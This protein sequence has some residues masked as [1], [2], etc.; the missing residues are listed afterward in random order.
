MKKIIWLVLIALM[1]L[2]AWRIYVQIKDKQTDD[3]GSG[4]GPMV[5]PVELAEVQTTTLRDIGSY[6]GS[7]KPRSGYTLAPKVAG[8]LNKLLVNLGDKVISGQ[9]IAVLDDE[10]YQQQLEQAK[11][12]QAVA[13]ATV[14]Q[15][16]LAYKAAEANWTATTSL[17]EQNYSSQAAMDQADTEKAAAKAKYDIALAE[18]QRTQSIVR[19]AEIQLAYTQI[20]ATWNGG[21]NYRLV[22]ERFA[23][24]GSLLSVNS[25]ILTLIDNSMVTATIDV[26]EKDYTRIKLGQQ[27]LVQTDAYPDKTFSG[28][29]VRLAPILQDA[30]RQA[31]AEIDIPNPEG[32]LKPGM[33]VKVQTI[34]AQHNNIV[35]VPKAAIVVKEGN[36]GVFLADDSTLTAKFVPVTTGITDKELIEIVEPPLSGKVIVLGQEQLQDGDKIKLPEKPEAKQKGKGKPGAKP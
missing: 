4:R 31:K 34:Y 30:S 9:L 5:V 25:P 6:S 12:Q 27:V 20:R 15:N 13:N 14:E 1:I 17:F 22:G 36:S 7:L 10:V 21:G 19:T 32:L 3:K 2:I 29:L 33:F 28:K 11:A 35:A 18:V 24:E 26:I 23:E 8:R 16:R